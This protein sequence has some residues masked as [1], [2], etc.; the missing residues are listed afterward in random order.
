MEHFH[1][2]VERAQVAIRETCTDQRISQ[3]VALGNAETFFVQEGA[4]TFAGGEELIARGI[5]DD[6]LGD[7]STVLQC[8]RDRVLREAMNK[9]G[10]AI[11]GINDPN[12][13]VV[14][15]QIGGRAGFFGQNR[16]IRVGLA[17]HFDDRLLGGLIHFSDKIVMVLGRD[18]QLLDFERGAIDDRGGAT[19]GFHRGIDHGMHG[20]SVKIGLA[21]DVSDSHHSENERCGTKKSANSRYFK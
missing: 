19:R 8:N 12:V 1:V 20:G 3:F 7:L 11:Q 4:A 15:M 16:M 13:F 6:G 14:V 2:F 21:T 5:V 18:A 9:V 17:Q 10:R